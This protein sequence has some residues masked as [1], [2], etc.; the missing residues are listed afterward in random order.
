MY[1]CTLTYK[2]YTHVE[3]II[4]KHKQYKIILDKTSH[5][6]VII[7]KLNKGMIVHFI[8]KILDR[9]INK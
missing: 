1:I 6:N 9:K 4:S 2:E 8:R 5:K 7:L 3:L